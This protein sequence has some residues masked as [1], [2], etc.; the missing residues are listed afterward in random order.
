MP[1]K[2]S[3]RWLYFTT[4]SP[5]I[6]GALGIIYSLVLLC[7]GV[8]YP[9]YQTREIWKVNEHF[10]T[11]RCFWVVGILLA[12]ALLAGVMPMLSTTGLQ[13]LLGTTLPPFFVVMFYTL[14]KDSMA[15][16]EKRSAIEKEICYISLSAYMAS[17]VLYVSGPMMLSITRLIPGIG[18]LTI[19]LA[20]KLELYVLYYLS[21]IYLRRASSTALFPL[22]SQVLLFYIYLIQDIYFDLTFI[23]SSLNEVS[24]W[25]IL[26]FDA[27]VNFIRASH[28]AKRGLLRCLPSHLR[29]A[30]FAIVGFFSSDLDLIEVQLK[31]FDSAVI[32]DEEESVGRG[33]GGGRIGE[34]EGEEVVKSAVAQHLTSIL[35]LVSQ[36]IGPSIVLVSMLM[37]QI[38][39][40]AKGGACARFLSV[41]ISGSEKVRR[42]ASCTSCAPD[43]SLTLF[44]PLLRSLQVE[45]AMLYII[46]LVVQTAVW[47]F[48]AWNDNKHRSKALKE[49]VASEAY[50]G[51]VIE[52]WREH[53]LFLVSTIC[54][55]CIFLLHA[56]MKHRW[57]LETGEEIWRE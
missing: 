29:N 39:C 17:A 43:K 45:T 15:Q 1:F 21:R 9:A 35:S 55:G 57:L 22:I 4:V 47:L 40:A 34:G 7:I 41:G 20:W 5:V 52:K 49:L 33:G 44:A 26:I 30:G 12:C 18:E 11:R 3:S 13:V 14:V 51:E 2:L 16:R 25:V 54:L 50:R 24:F 19:A 36:T 32:D 27:G 38:F 6:Q 46:V 53:T 37:E 10:E 23:D 28:T 56:A 31:A 42:G 8:F 48:G